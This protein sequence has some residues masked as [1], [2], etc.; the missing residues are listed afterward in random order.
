M[1]KNKNHKN[2]RNKVTAVN[3]PEQQTEFDNNVLC[4]LR[5]RGGTDWNSILAHAFQTLASLPRL[6]VI[7]Q[8]RSLMSLAS[9]QS[10]LP[11]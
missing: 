4:E 5:V 8:S 11:Q 7:C 10:S 3:M 6:A 1:N 2:E 9:R